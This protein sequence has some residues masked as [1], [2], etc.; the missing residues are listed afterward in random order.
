M[1]PAKTAMP[2]GDAGLLI[3]TAFLW[4]SNNIAAKL[5]IDDMPP[6]FSAGLR[7]AITSLVLLPFLRIPGDQV[8]SM[9]GVALTS[10][11]IHFGLLYTSFHLATAIGSLCDH[12]LCGISRRALWHPASGRIGAGIC[13]SRDHRF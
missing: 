3:L 1:T 4:A 12:P 5:I 10:G 11:P 9:L 7:F 8:K 6:V 13:R 2:L